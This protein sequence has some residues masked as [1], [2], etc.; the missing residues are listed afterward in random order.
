MQRMYPMFPLGWP[1][2]ALVLL[3]GAVSV[4]LVWLATA[5]GLLPLAGAGL[6]LA[7][8]LA[9]FGLLTPLA[10]VVAALAELAF[11]VLGEGASLVHPLLA[12]DPLLLLM[13]GPGAYSLDCRLFGRRLITISG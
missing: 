8:L 9:M 2:L 1:G 10:S 5:D 7:A 6:W 13:L 3:R 11:A 12:L 4:H